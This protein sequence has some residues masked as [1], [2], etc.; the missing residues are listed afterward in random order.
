MI[1]LLFSCQSYNCVVN[2]IDQLFKIVF[3]KGFYD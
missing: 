2:D 1:C 3:E